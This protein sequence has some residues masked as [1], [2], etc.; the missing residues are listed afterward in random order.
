[1]MSRR[2]P[3][4]R[5]PHS[6][7]TGPEIRAVERLLAC[8]KSGRVDRTTSRQIGPQL[9]RVGI[10]R[11]SSSCVCQ[12]TWEMPR[13]RKRVGERAVGRRSDDNIEAGSGDGRQRREHRPLAAEERR[14][15]A[16][17]QEPR[18]DRRSGEPRPDIERCHSLPRHAQ[19]DRG[20]YSKP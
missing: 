1:M 6:A 19:A 13:S 9:V 4:L 5:T 14:V 12:A 17:N 10:V 11:R 8:S 7:A 2:W 3:M 15:L 16:E 20:T 18:H